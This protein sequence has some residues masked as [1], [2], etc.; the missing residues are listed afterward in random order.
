[1]GATQAGPFKPPAH[2]GAVP[3][4][5]QQVSITALVDEAIQYLL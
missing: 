2:T 5:P 1:M 4:I 3:A